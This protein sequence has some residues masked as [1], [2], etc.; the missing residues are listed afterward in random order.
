[1]DEDFHMDCDYEPELR[2]LREKI[3]EMSEEIRGCYLEDSSVEVAT[4]I[5]GYIAKK[6]YKRHSCSEC[7]ALMTLDSSSGPNLH[8]GNDYLLIL[9]RGVS[10][11]HTKAHTK[12]TT[13]P[14]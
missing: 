7:K 8:P 2:N 14:S 10:K 13:Q 11:Y 9:S 3:E 4:V 5:S 6:I 1:M 12:C